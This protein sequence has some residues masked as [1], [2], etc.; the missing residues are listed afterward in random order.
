MN[1]HPPSKGLRWVDISLPG[2]RAALDDAAEHS[3]AIDIRANAYGFGE[4]LLTT[5][6]GE[7]NLDVDGGSP[8]W[9]ERAHA[10]GAQ[11]LHATV[12]HVKSVPEGESVSYGGHFTTDKPTTLALISAGFADG[13]PRLDPVGGEIELA[14]QRVPITG[15]IAMDQMI[16]DATGLDVSPGDVATIWGGLVSMHEW[17]TWSGRSVWEI[18]STLAERVRVSEVS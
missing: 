6:A 18:G 11:K 16:V 7:K 8:F 12:I 10:H 13:V 1:P 3:S 5:L 14:G 4:T 2:L 15:R 9:V 17:A